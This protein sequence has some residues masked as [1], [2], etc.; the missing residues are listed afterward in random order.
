V[1]AQGFHAEALAPPPTRLAFS[2]GSS[3]H[4]PTAA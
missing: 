3:T 1:L 4:H 2:K